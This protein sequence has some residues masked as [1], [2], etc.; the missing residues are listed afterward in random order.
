VRKRLWVQIEREAGGRGVWVVVVGGGEEV[1][2][3]M[4]I[5]NLN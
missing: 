5:A 2:G 3:F 4:Y 1:K